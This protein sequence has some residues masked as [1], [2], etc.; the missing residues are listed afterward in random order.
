M[1]FEDIIVEKRD[2]IATVTF[3]RPEKPE[4]VPRPDERRAAGGA[5]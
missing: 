3:N 1:P 4:R 2:H 5:G